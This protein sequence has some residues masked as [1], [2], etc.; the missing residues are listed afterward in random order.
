[1]GVLDGD[2]SKQGAEACEVTGAV[3]LAW[4]DLLEHQRWL[5]TNR[6]LPIAEK[7]A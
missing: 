1:M 2:G 3:V 4:A 7:E 6:L 5:M